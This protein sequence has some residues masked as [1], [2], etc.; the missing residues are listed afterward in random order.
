[1][2]DPEPAAPPKETPL[3]RRRRPLS[4]S[5]TLTLGLALLLL[6]S[7][8]SSSWISIEAARRNTLELLSSVAILTVKTVQDQVTS[9]IDA[10]QDQATFLA[11][12]IQT[13]EVDSGDD[14]RLA[15]LMLG[16]LAAAPQV[17]GIAFVRSDY[18]VI[19]AGRIDG[20]LEILFD[21]WKHRPEIVSSFENSLILADPSWRAV[22]W[23]EEFNAP[24]I[25]VAEA[26]IKDNGLVGLFFS[27]ISIQSLSTY[28]EG[29][30]DISEAHSFILR[31]REEVLAHSSLAKG[32]AGLSEEK[33]LPT[34]ADIGDPALAA[35][36]KPPVD[37]LRNI[38]SG[39]TI[40]GHV[41]EG[42]EDDYIYLYNDV[43]V[44]G[45]ES[46][47]VGVYYN[48]SEVNDPFQRLIGATIVGVIILV[49]AVLGGLLV[50]RSIARPINRLAAASR[51][52]SNLDLTD[53]KPL[54]GSP[55]SEL[56]VAAKA[57]NSMLAGLRW[58]ETYVP[59]SLV[60]RLM[61]S[62]GTSV[63]SEER[64]VTILFTDIVGFTEIG[65]AL[66]PVELAALLNRHFTQLADAIEA[67]EGT[68]DKYIGDSI[69]AF[70]GAPLDQDDHAERACRA[71]LAIASCVSR[72]NQLRRGRGEAPLRLRVGLNSGL[73]IAGNI[74]A[75]GRVNYTLIGDTVNVAQRLEALGK[76]VAP[77][78][79]VVVLIDANTKEALGEASGLSVPLEPLG[80]FVLRGRGYSSDVYRLCVEQAENDAE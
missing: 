50:A 49:V 25:I 5:R 57:F 66:S 52:V 51:Q 70:W 74:G 44:G 12:L 2:T 19:R 10:A 59:R 8:G 9:Y 27:V 80:G 18:S 1:M 7:L 68:V 30:D 26:V 75:P 28:L 35:I 32:F 47:I 48:G 11:D 78:A 73:A 65:A 56:D 69:M 36:W 55:F 67:E 64:A 72:E 4:L 46:W 6:V 79:E 14:A 13:G 60:L 71:A 61:R 16:A 54:R 45:L 20:E 17:S 34:R 21:S 43:N 77:E 33:E 63:R 24:H 23:V 76:E 62:G 39:S 41:V 15:D 31:G 53:V 40:Q 38:L 42:D 22:G 37:D 29:F 3:P 58:F